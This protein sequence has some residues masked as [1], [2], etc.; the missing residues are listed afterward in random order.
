MWLVAISTNRTFLSSHKV[1]WAAQGCVRGRQETGNGE[2]RQGLQGGLCEEMGSVEMRAWV[3]A[4]G[5]G[6]GGRG[7]Q[8]RAA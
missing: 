2:T 4:A 5:R 6:L 7:E 1:P 3:R 8:E